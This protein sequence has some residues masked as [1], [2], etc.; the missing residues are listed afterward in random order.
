[1]KPAPVP[2]D[3]GEVDFSSAKT[4]DDVFSMGYKYMA[5]LQFDK[6]GISSWA[7]L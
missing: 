7:S 6:V 1:M 5:A 4:V 2:Q 3:S